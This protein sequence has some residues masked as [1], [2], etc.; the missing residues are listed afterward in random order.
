MTSFR[1]TV[2]IVFRPIG[3]IHTPFRKPEGTPI[4]PAG[5]TDVEGWI[6]IFPEF[7]EGLSD[8]DGFSHLILLYHCN[9][10][11]PFQLKVAPFLDDREHG[12]FAT[13]SPS[14][15]NPIGISVVR[16]MKVGEDRL[17]IRDLD[18]LDRTPLLDLKPYV[19]AFDVRECDRIG[20]LADRHENAGTMRDDGRF[21][22]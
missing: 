16:L 11:K 19:P 17:V 6:E 8:L 4:Q 22:S 10:A 18:I 7:G 1:A 15:P 21:S 12:V 20:W 9:Q 3:I 5:G 13:R 2:P 14:R